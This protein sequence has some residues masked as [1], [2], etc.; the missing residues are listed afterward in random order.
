MKLAITGKD[1]TII[2]PQLR[3]INQLIDAALQL[4]QVLVRLINTPLGAS[5]EPNIDEIGLRLWRYFKAKHYSAA[6]ISLRPALLTADISSGRDLPLT[7]P[8]LSACLSS[9]RRSW[10][11]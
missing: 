3:M 7:S 1:V 9:K 8:F 11:C 5:V 4:I 6:L 10:E 2:E